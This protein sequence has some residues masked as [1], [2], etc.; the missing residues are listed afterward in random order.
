V[1]AKSNATI[2]AIRIGL[3]DI[4]DFEAQ[5]AEALPKLHTL[6]SDAWAQRLKASSM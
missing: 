2:E 5:Q 1:L 6:G 4:N 3:N